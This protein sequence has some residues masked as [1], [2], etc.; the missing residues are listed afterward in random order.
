MAILPWEAIFS[1]AQPM[2]AIIESSEMRSSVKTCRATSQAEQSRGANFWIF[3][4]ELCGRY[5]ILSMLQPQHAQI[6]IEG[7]FRCFGN[8]AGLTQCF[9]NLLGNAVKFVA[10]GVAP[11]SRLAETHGNR[12]RLLS[13]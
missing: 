4:Q 3:A 12:V 1:E 6:S 11:K 2:A 8:E 13:K 7:P 5:R 9:S 10:P